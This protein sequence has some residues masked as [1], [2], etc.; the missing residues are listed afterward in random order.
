[1]ENLSRIMSK[2]IR[3]LIGEKQK[4][5]VVY[6]PNLCIYNVLLINWS[7]TVFRFKCF[8]S[9]RELLT[10]CSLP[11]LSM[12][13]S[14]NN[15]SPIMEQWHPT[16]RHTVTETAVAEE[17]CELHAAI[18]TSLDRT[19][20]IISATPSVLPSRP[21]VRPSFVTADAPTAPPHLLLL[22]LLYIISLL[23][24]LV[25]RVQTQI[26]RVDQKVSCWF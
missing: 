8:K 12:I 3:R 23:W 6:R 5:I 20:R 18:T 21:V 26:Y 1:M 7:Q 17:R 13:W 10:A 24:A 19:Y 14:S 22:L 15:W 2:C 16:N 25:R 11:A 9:Y 4:N